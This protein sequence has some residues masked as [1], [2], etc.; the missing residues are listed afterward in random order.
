MASEEHRSRR[1]SYFYNNY[2]INKVRKSGY[3]LVILLFVCIYFMIKDK[4]IILLIVTTP[5][6]IVVFVKTIYL[7]IK[8]AYVKSKNTV[9][10]ELDDEGMIH[11]QLSGKKREI[12]YNNIKKIELD[13]S[14]L[15]IG[16]CCEMEKKKKYFWKNVF[17]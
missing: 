13:S 2:E 9:F 15:I 10:L 12:A 17:Q 1:I 5:L 7:L 6:L 3:F 16:L 4:D 8:L 11:Y 14:G